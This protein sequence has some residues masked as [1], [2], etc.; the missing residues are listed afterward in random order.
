M[1]DQQLYDLPNS[2][3]AL[4]LAHSCGLAEVCSVPTDGSG[5]VQM[6]SSSSSQPLPQHSKAIVGENAEETESAGFQ[7]QGSKKFTKSEEGGYKTVKRDLTSS[8]E[9]DVDPGEEPLREDVS[10]EVKDPQSSD[11]AKVQATSKLNEDETPYKS[12]ADKPSSVTNKEPLPPKEQ[13]L[14][15]QD[16]TVLVHHSSTADAD[17]T[18]AINGQDSCPSTHDQTEQ[19][20]EQSQSI[21][22]NLLDGKESLARRSGSFMFQQRQSKAIE[23]S[24]E[25]GTTTAS[26]LSALDAK[27]A[28]DIVTLEREKQQVHEERRRLEQEW[29]KLEEERQKLA[30]ER[31]DFQKELSNISSKK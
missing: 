4:C 1:E 25:E 7:R 17:A 5:Y 2:P 24:A 8:K 28:V 15:E 14:H 19:T 23:E 26:Y 10:Q 21:T 30:Q 13:D 12:A 16:I 29:H 20:S 11:S 27:I 18:S 22:D 9:S 31:R 3:N 6:G